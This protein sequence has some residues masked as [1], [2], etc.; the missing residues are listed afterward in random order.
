MKTK[1]LMIICTAVLFYICGCSTSKVPEKPANMTASQESAKVQPAQTEKVTAASEEKPAH[2]YSAQEVAEMLADP[3]AT[4]T[5]FNANYR[6]Y[7]DVGPFDKTNQEL[8]LNGAGFLNLKDGSSIL[9]RA[10]LPMYSS[11]FPFDDQG[12]GDA[13]ISAYWFQKRAA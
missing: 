6:S 13:L 2:K 11:E 5:Y 10:F 8:R 9:Y 4:I 3:S 1:L 12:I 7:T